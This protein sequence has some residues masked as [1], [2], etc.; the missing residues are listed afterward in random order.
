MIKSYEWID[1]IS[2]IECG[3]FLNAILFIGAKV[4]FINFLEVFF[5]AENEM[6]CASGHHQINDGFKC[7][8]KHPSGGVS[9]VLLLLLDTSIIYNCIVRWLIYRLSEMLKWTYLAS[10]WS[11][12][13]ERPDTF[14]HAIHIE[15]KQKCSHTIVTSAAY[16]IYPVNVACIRTLVDEN[17]KLN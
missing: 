8:I 9:D 4:I 1:S 12:P 2:K 17:I 13:M 16:Q 11:L 7:I 6:F 15:M 10:K 3:K 14:F 5:C